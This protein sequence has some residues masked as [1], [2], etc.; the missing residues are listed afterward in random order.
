MVKHTPSKTKHLF[1]IYIHLYTY[2]IYRPN[3]WI[4]YLLTNNNKDSH[5]Q[6]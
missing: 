3:K 6:S 1:R 4:R 2:D 5:C